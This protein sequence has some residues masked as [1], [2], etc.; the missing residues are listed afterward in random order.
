MGWTAIKSSVL[1]LSQRLTNT[2]PRQRLVALIGFVVGVLIIPAIVGLAPYLT[3]SSEAKPREVFTA[4]STGGAPAVAPVV[5]PSRENPTKAIN[6]RTPVTRQSPAD[7]SD[8]PD[9]AP[10][11]N[12]EKAKTAKEPPAESASTSLVKGMEIE[13]PKP[14]T[15]TIAVVVEV[16]EGHVTEAYIKAPRPGLGAY[17]ATALRMA[18]QR[19][20][21]KGTNGKETI[22]LMVTRE[23]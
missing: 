12:S 17:E 6:E 3:N 9:P 20:F 18:R 7:I 16:N 8:H 4:E 22:N 1:S 15:E 21:P 10:A 23:P 2:S 13:P 11:M 14:L 19:R 5:E